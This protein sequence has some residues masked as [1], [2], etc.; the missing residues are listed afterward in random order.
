MSDP[1]KAFG[2]YYLDKNKTVLAQKLGK[3]VK[4]Q[5]VFRLDQKAGQQN[6]ETSENKYIVGIYL[7]GFKY[8]D[9]DH[10]VKKIALKIEPELKYGS[11]KIQEVHV[12]ISGEMSDCSGHSSD[13]LE[14]GVS[15]AAYSNDIQLSGAEGEETVEIVALQE[16]SVEYPDDD[17]HV[18]EYSVSISADGINGTAQI[19]DD[20]HHTGNG[21]AKGK[22]I[23]APATLLGLMISEDV[24][25]INDF[26]L[27]KDSGDHHVRQTGVKYI[28]G[29]AE[30]DL[31]DD[32]GNYA[33]INC[34]HCYANTYKE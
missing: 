11:D 3:E 24:Q 5:M 14:I 1:T 8:K 16:F 26:K 28:N 23:K 30:F 31:S 15:L 7:Y 22:K 27:A 12:N 19:V 21:T 29:H 34:C 4:G 20:S 32:S 25:C 13:T 6:F 18:K 9:S 17:H 33:S 10:H 2:N